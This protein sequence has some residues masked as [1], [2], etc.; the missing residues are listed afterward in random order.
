MKKVTFLRAKKRALAAFNFYIRIRDGIKTTG[1]TKR[2]VC[3][4]CPKTY[5]TQGVGCIQGGHFIPGRHLSVC[6]D[7][8]NCHA[9]CYVCNVRLKGNAV[10]YFRKMQETYGDEIIKEL[11]AMDKVVVN[12]KAYELLAIEEEYQEKAKQLLQSYK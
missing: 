4:T 2:A 5:P 1:T 9:Q 8:R 6:F 3:F 11:E 7:E 10:V 12:M